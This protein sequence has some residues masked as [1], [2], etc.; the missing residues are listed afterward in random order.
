MAESGCT[1]AAISGETGPLHDCVEES[2]D[3][4]DS[5]SGDSDSGLRIICVSCGDSKNETL[6]LETPCQ[7]HY[8]NDCIVNLFQAATTDE[9][10][11]PPRC[12]Q[13][14][15]P[16]EDA[17]EFLPAGFTEEFRA[18]EEEFSTSNRTYCCVAECSTFI[19]QENITDDGLASCPKC[20][21]ATCAKCKTAHHEGECQGDADIELVKRMAQEHGWQTCYSCQRIIELGTGCNHMSEYGRSPSVSIS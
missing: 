12:Y 11:F 20:H 3:G 16:P 6:I 8:C 13:Q 7:H 9:S 17:L 14:P 15:V 2:P 10:L 21:A 4:P 5:D 19:C 1:Q 18:K